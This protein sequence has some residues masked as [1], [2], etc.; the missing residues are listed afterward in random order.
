MAIPLSVGKYQPIRNTYGVQAGAG[1]GGGGFQPAAM[2]GGQAPGPPIS[3]GTGITKAGGP[4]GGGYFHPAADQQGATGG[5]LPTIQLP[6]AQAAIPAFTPD[7]ASM[8]GGSYEVDAAESA[9]ASQMAA[10]RAQF[11]AQ[12][13][14][15]FIDLGYSG[16]MTKDNGLGD[17]S[18]YIDKDTIQKA[19][20][21]KYSAYAQVK[22][23]E[24]KTNAA[25]DA[26][27]AS[28]GL[29][30][31]GTTTATATDT[32]NQAEQARYEGLRNFLSGG[33]AG[34]SNLTNLKLQLAQ[35][36]AQAR[37][38]AASRL[39]QMYPPTPGVPAQQPNWDDYWGS[40]AGG[41]WNMPGG[42]WIVQSGV[43][44]PQTGGPA[45]WYVGPGSGV[46]DLSWLHPHT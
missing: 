31:G 2:M 12:L 39:A 46:P 17:F 34:L 37:A 22:Q 13:R 26:L 35:G 21:N 9:M 24:A 15:N 41:T 32:I 45:P 14:Q 20:D 16:D 4:P 30:L 7:Y 44:N 43:P 6:Q 42:G 33:Q 19:I 3:G 29:S 11:Q 40:Y 25:N 8:I 28:S 38:A 10:A 36:V 5:V 18:K 1:G 27:L 23:Q